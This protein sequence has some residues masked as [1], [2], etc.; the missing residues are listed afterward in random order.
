LGGGRPSC[1][2]RLCEVESL[3]V[4]TA[5]ALTAALLA[6]AAA[7]LSTSAAAADLSTSTAAADLP[8][9]AVRPTCPP[10]PTLSSAPASTSAPDPTPAPGLAPISDRWRLSNEH[11]RVLLTGSKLVAGLLLSTPA[12]APREQRL[13]ASTLLPAGLNA[14][15]AVSADCYLRVTRLLAK[16]VRDMISPNDPRL[17]ADG[18]A[19]CADRHEATRA[20]GWMILSL[21]PAPVLGLPGA[22]AAAIRGAMGKQSEGEGPRSQAVDDTSINTYTSP[23]ESLPGSASE[24]SRLAVVR[25][26]V[27]AARSGVKWTPPYFEALQR[28]QRA[29]RVHDATDGQL[30]A[31]LTSGLASDD[32]TE[33]KSSLAALRHCLGA[34]AADS[35]PW[36]QFIAMYN[37]LEDFAAHLVRSLHYLPQVRV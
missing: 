8:T 16:G 27:E 1:A 17:G 34:A 13:L 19:Q 32:V 14:A 5:V 2:G 10:A 9:S 30:V 22:A 29:I 28:A 6:F 4:E 31:V 36:I 11:R 23:V 35:S 25:S 26:R 33:R 20:A 7:D 24:A 18:G 3:R 21:M 12:M 15:A 37:S